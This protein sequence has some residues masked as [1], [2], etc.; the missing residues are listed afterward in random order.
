MFGMKT[1][2][3]VTVLATT[4][5]VANLAS[6]QTL[7]VAGNESDFKTL[8]PDRATS[9]TDV[10]LVSWIFNGLVRF[11]PGSADPAKIE[12]DLAKSWES[13]DDEK[14]WTFHL[15][16]G[17]KFQGDFGSLT[18]DDVVYSLNRAKDP[19]RSAFAS[20]YSAFEKIEAVDSLTVRI[21]LSRPVP[22]FLGLVANYHGG[23]I[24]SKKA[25]EKYGKDFKRHPIGTGPFMF[26]KGVTQQYVHLVAFKDYFRGSPK[27]D[28]IRY[29]FI[30]SDSSRNLA[31]RSGELDLIVGRR[32]QR[33]VEQANGWDGAHVDV[34]GPGEFRTLY[35]NMA[36]KPLDKLKVRQAIA[37]AVNVDQII[38]FVG[39]DVS[40]KGCSVVPNGYLGEDCS[41]SYKYDPE[42]AQKL[43]A[44]AGYPNGLKLSAVVSSI[45]SHLPI[46]QVIQAQLAQV[47]I[48]LKLRVVDHPTYHQ[49]IR[50][51]V[52]DLVFYG[53][54]RFP[55]ADSYL[56]QFYDSKSIVGTPTAV[57][58][59]SHCRV[60][61]SEIEGAQN[62]GS[63][64]ERLKLW[65]LAQKKIH[66]K[67]CSVPLFSL[68]Q[69]WAQSDALHLGYDLKGS[70]NLAPPITEQTTLTR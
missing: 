17:V 27:L 40:E 26:D 44:E 32:E 13:S 58:N 10:T 36:H 33:W 11:P 62:T 49:R 8:D 37:N 16:Q 39:G 59:F 2:L 47:G 24:L 60:A 43:L 6:A 42:R 69:V 41:W 31:F 9:T 25:A 48:D 7:R 1:V 22:D 28:G 66:D 64:S 18:A 12:P 51:D 19:E 61:D 45:T 34:F 52:S 68:M 29:R 35:I 70:L 30:P 53:A 38:Q 21:T 15:R 50:Q 67:V 46:M 55:V 57:T 20:D 56:S 3:H 63:Q 4:L 23:Q 65:S 5:L 54:A 14:V